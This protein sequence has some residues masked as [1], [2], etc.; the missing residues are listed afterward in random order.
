MDKPYYPHVAIAS[1]EK[2]ARTLGLHPNRL[3]SIASKVDESYTEYQLIDKN[4]TVYEPKYELK[5]IQKRI[6]SRIFEKVEFP[7][8]LQGGIKA[9]KKRDYVENA[10]IHA[11]AETLISL[12]IKKF[13][14]N[15]KE[16]KVWAIYKYFFKFPDEVTELLVQ[17]TTFKGRVPQGG[18][19]SSYLANLVFF[20]SEYRLVSAFRGQKI[21]YSRLLDDVTLST[22]KNLDSESCSKAIKSVVGMFINHGLKLNTKKT[23]IEYRG[24]AVKGFEVTG[25]WVEHKKP[26]LRRCDRRYIR[27]LVYNCELQYKTL[28]TTVDYHELWNKTSGQ[29]AKLSRLNH[30]QA[31]RLRSRL[32]LVLPKYDDYDAKKIK[33]LANKLL[34]VPTEQHNKIGRIKDYNKLMYKI[35]ILSRSHKGL[36]RDLTKKLKAYYINV[37]TKKE[38]WLE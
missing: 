3:I 25:L 38:Y 31:A 37:P 10:K 15:I 2:L 35:G 33:I 8:Y 28:C 20:N 7:T 6:N 24:K 16:D 21:K 1:I 36:S 19:T 12:D 29:V 18:C 5:K 32:K 17:L 22:E 26:K 4:R 23:K 11:N 30:P 27:Q 13:Y 34:K 14:T 9:E